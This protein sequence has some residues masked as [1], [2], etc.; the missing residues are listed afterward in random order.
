MKMKVMVFE[1]ERV[2]TWYGVA[3]KDFARA[4]RVCY[5][6]PINWL[7]RWGRAVHERL[8]LGPRVRLL[9]EHQSRLGAALNRLESA[10]DRLD[11]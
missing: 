1:C 4:C 6:I 11:K 10:L 7:V 5:P 3:H 2:P 8:M 9:S